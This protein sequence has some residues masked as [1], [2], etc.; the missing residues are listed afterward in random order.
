MALAMT[1]LFVSGTAAISLKMQWVA[2][3][4]IVPLAMSASLSVIGFWL[5]LTLV[6]GRVYCSMV[7]PMGVL[8][9]V[10][11]RSRRLTRRNRQRHV[12]RFRPSLNSLRLAV[13][14]AV[15]VT[16]C[17]GIPLLISV[18]DPYS[19]YGRIA[20]NLFRPLVDIMLS[21][22][23]IVGTVAGMTVAALSFIIVGAIAYRS[24]RTLCNTVCP[25]G[26]A[27]GLLSRF[28]IFHFEIDTDTCV[29]CN[30]CEYVCKSHC[31]NLRDS[32]VDG[33][34]CV[35]CFNCIAVCPVGSIRYTVTRKKLSI[36]MMQ[37]A[38][39]TPPQPSASIE[40]TTGIAETRKVDRRTFLATGL[41][42]AIGP[43]VNAADRAVSRVKAMETG[44]RPLQ[45][46]RHVSPPGALS[47]ALFLERCTGCGLCIAECTGKVLRAADRQYGLRNALHPVMDFESGYCLYNCNRCTRLCPTGALVPLTREEKHAY[48]IGKARIEP[49]N[50]IG[51]GMCARRCP[52]EAI[53]MTTLHDNRRIATLS[54]PESCIGCGACE[55]I[56]PASPVKAIVVDGVTDRHKH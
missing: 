27:L 21:R 31:I 10:A 15:V 47:H 32:T 34:R 9:D 7:C 4:Q 16:A 46:F 48:V 11:A 28:S 45:R 35:N 18:T 17:I 2:R 54:S 50:C 51:C 8:Q 14:I 43:A 53:T 29:H 19:A 56:C 22:E 3:L 52:R 25:V 20:G 24:G 13:A 23:V 37:R 1:L 42:V 49:D 41:F 55:Y 44:A 38:D 39:T 33:S 12:Y 30:K 36:P 5:L 6:F 40:N 26:S